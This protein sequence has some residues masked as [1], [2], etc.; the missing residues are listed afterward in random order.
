VRRTSRKNTFFQCG[1]HSLWL[2]VSATKRFGESQGKTE[3]LGIENFST[4]AILLFLL[5]YYSS[6]AWTVKRKQ[7]DSSTVFKLILNQIVFTQLT[8]GK[9]YIYYYYKV[10]VGR[11]SQNNNATVKTIS[12][13]SITLFY[14]ELYPVN[15]FYVDKYWTFLFYKY[16]V[17]KQNEVEEQPFA[18][19]SRIFLPKGI[20][21]KW[22]TSV[23]PHYSNCLRI[24][25]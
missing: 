14:T 16:V 11:T 21:L 19:F 22:P 18:K 4:I 6:V 15:T 10:L 8:F 5:L 7:I 3:C 25:I 13:P 20:M 24:R 2:K 23:L 9:P 1:G 12:I 17:I